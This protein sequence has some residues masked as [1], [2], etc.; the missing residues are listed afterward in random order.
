MTNGIDSTCRLLAASECAYWIGD[1]KRPQDCPQYETAA[2]VSPPQAFQ[3][4]HDDIDACLI[5]ETAEEIVLA[6]RGTLPFNVEDK[7]TIYDWIN[8]LLVK[9]V[10]VEG[11]PGEVHEGFHNAVNALWPDFLPPLRELFGAGKPLA[12]TGHSKGAAMV[13]IAIAKLH[14]TENITAAKARMF[15]SPRPGDG[16]F[17]DYFNEIMTDAVRYENRDDIVPH[18]PSTSQLLDRLQDL[19]KM[20]D[21]FRRLERLNYESVGKLQYID[22]DGDIV[23]ESWSLNLRR[24]KHLFKMLREGKFGKIVNDHKLLGGYCAA[25]CPGAV[26]AGGD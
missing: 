2:F 22:R 17:R 9:Q 7:Q 19:P 10:S 6:F 12:V 4:G 20:G 16:P 21:W 26:C 14:A 3:A 8:N 11:V 18:L 25:V 1:S 24:L 13:P 23:G 5:G 15:A